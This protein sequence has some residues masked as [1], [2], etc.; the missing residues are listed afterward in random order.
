MCFSYKIKSHVKEGEPYENGQLLVDH[1]KG[2]R[3]IA[4]ATTRM[5]GVIGEI[6]EVL[7]LICMCHDFGKASSCFQ[8]HLKGEYHGDLKNHGEIS[9][10]FTYYMLP[11]KWKL[12]GFMCVKK[13]HGDMEPDAAFFD[14]SN[15]KNL[16][17]IA[18]DIKLN[19]TELK[20][21][22]GKDIS[23]FFNL[24]KDSRFL[25]KPL[26]DFIKKTNRFTVE[27]WIWLQY[28]WSL[29]LIGDKTQLIRGSAYINKT[30]IYEDYIKKY[31]EKVKNELVKKHPMIENTELF[32]IRN[33]I[34]D[35]II[36]S[37]DNLDLDKSH[38]L[39]INVP[40]G[41]GKTLG[42]YGGAFRLA[43]RI[44]KERRGQIPSIIYNLP[45]TSVIDQNYEVLEDIL[46]ESSVKSYD[47]FILK[48]HSLSELK[49]E[50]D[51][52]KE[53]KNFDARFC[54]ENWQSTIITTTFVQL[55]N[56]IFRPGVNSICN[57]FHKLAGSIIILDE[58]Q[59]VPPKYFRI[60]EEVFNVLCSKFNV[61]VIT[62]T[63]TKPLFL[64]GEELVKS[65]REFFSVLDRIQIINN[66]D[67][68]ISLEEFSDIALE[69]ITKNPDK[70][71]LI[72]LNTVKSSLKILEKLK[73]SG[74][75]VLYLSTE[76]FPVRR[77][78]LIRQIKKDKS[79]K[80]VLVST[81]LIEAG[82]DL[83][84]D[85]VY[86]DF[87][88]ID[89]INQT[90][91]RA[92]RN[93]VKGK[94]L[95]K[96]FMIMNEDHNNK[97]FCRYIYPIS[98]LEATERILSGK[99][100]ISERDILSINEEYFRQVDLIKNND[101]SEN[102]A[103]YIKRFDFINIIKNFKLIDDDFN[104][105]DIIINFN[106]ETQKWFDQLENGKLEYQET[107][108]LWR[109]LNKYRVSVYKKDM[110]DISCYEVKG[111]NVLNREDYDENKGIIRSG[112]AIC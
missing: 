48:H 13:H 39:S 98:L 20:N 21:I 89:S 9:A 41:T 5:H 90:A 78:E 30:N 65:N 99:E 93:A 6:E 81:Q 112:T 91:G 84:F 61:Y 10:Y 111:V 105:E 72:V 34:Y 25:R 57:R 101:S 50:D 22:Y 47:S 17:K 95:V 40:T 96:L 31:Q 55:F 16:V 51:E 107:I 24:I 14:V 53:Y 15:E 104:K 46:E 109:K 1:L 76:I 108:N 36:N 97:Q 37:I 7:E 62:V 87:S 35:E 69:D 66:I 27:D 110:K 29:L 60:I 54:V 71:F 68:P 49:Y 38:I 59:A 8:K 58:V 45:F 75:E 32:K 85:I 23:E 4:L 70:S 63:A 82:V 80:Y 33:T 86:R 3:D 11:E 79:K 92:N 2:V 56:S 42:V 83:D 77:L 64:V 88:T 43:E 12:I 106:E 67:K 102:I 52:N 73:E 103:E 26:K 28:L 94:G 44:I 18:E 19:K 74:R 100:I